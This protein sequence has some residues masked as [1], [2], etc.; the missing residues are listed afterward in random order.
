M[1]AVL[2]TKAAGPMLPL[3]TLL[4]ATTNVLSSD[5][6]LRTAPSDVLKKRLIELITKDLP[7]RAELEERVAR[8]KSLFWHALR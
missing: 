8:A 3:I 6:G 7:R 1:F 4:T 5:I 2:K